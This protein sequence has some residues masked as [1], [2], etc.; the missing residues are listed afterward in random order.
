MHDYLH[1]TAEKFHETEAWR[2]L[3]A[4]FLLRARYGDGVKLGV[5]L[6]PDRRE[7]L[8]WRLQCFGWGATLLVSATMTSYLS[9][10]Y[11]LVLSAFR[12]AFGVVLSAFLLRPL[13]RRM[14]ESG[15]VF[16]PSRVAGILALCASLGVADTVCTLVLA[17]LLRVERVMDVLREVFSV[18][19][20]MR[21]ALYVFW[22]ILYF[23]IHSLFDAQQEQL[24]AARTEA[25]LR[26]GELQMLRSQ[27]NPHFLFNALNSLLAAS[28]EPATVRQLTLALTD[29][30]RFSLQQRGDL[31]RL[32]VELAALESYLRV[33]KVRFE[34][35]F[36]YVLETGP[37]VVDVLVPVALV[38]PLL[39]NAIKYGQLAAIR[40]LRVEIVSFIEGETLVVAV[41]NSGCWVEPGTHPSTGIGLANLRRRLELLYGD[42]ASLALVPAEASVTSRIQLPVA[43]PS[44]V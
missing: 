15:P 31:E 7:S 33:E 41:T 21:A 1:E 23:G 10:E 29:Y 42:R 4:F 22:S 18:S 14:R 6:D 26:A 32:G 37:G 34:E 17:D 44:P 16:T 12:T 19:L 5:S 40:P 24:R 30:L 20:P 3:G 2:V 39:E 27:V 36:E 8:F 38:Q 28:D 43:P 13:Y 9:L 35:Q 25:A 11:G